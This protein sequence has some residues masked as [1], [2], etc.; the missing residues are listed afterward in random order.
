MK[1]ILSKHPFFEKWTDPDSG[2]DSY[3]LTKRVAPVQ[4]SFYFTNPNLSAD[5]KWL[6]F[7]AAFPP[8]QH[9]VLG[10][11]CMD[12]DNPRIHLLPEAEFCEVS[13]MV[14]PEG[15][16]AYFCSG[17]SVWRIS[18]DKE[19]TRICTLSEEYIDHRHL[20]RLASHLTV[21]ADGKY[22]L[23]DGEVGNQWFV[24]VGDRR[25]GEVKVL[26]EFG[27]RYEHGQFSPVDPDLFLLAQDWWHDP[28]SGRY[29]GFDK[30][31]WIM[32][33]RQTL[34]EPLVPNLWFDH[35]SKPC[36]E[37]FSGDGLI[38]W[39]DYE[40][41]AYECDVSDRRPRLVWPGP[42]CHTHC[43]ANRQFWCA[44]ESPY[45]WTRTPCRIK[46]FD[47]QRQQEV[48]IVTAMPQ[49]PMPRRLYHL[50]PHPQI[51]PKATFVVYTTMVRG[52]VDVALTPVD[53]I[54]D[55]MT[56]NG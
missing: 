7:Y 21:S 28:I 20:F 55:K 34:F 40:E 38:C 50:D 24:A 45:K 10:A 5:E 17:P 47:R 18:V 3:I 56:P 41:G 35:G 49:P 13:P 31:T 32:N 30:R 2:I 25:S 42:L 12:P 52:M 8:A 16:A 29:T 6:W 39:T 46:F 37:W 26:H 15:D 53:D 48:D 44:D 43:D 11:V 22:F 23:L 14:T 33:V 4:Q 1:D 9:Q 27:R 51:S 19:I 36:H 54:L